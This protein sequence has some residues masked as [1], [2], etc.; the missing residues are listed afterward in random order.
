[1]C[2]VDFQVGGGRACGAGR[3]GRRAAGPKHCR[4]HDRQDGVPSKKV[5]FDL[6]NVARVGGLV[7]SVFVY[8]Q[9]K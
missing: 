5:D 3:G 9:C 7:L 4:L 8:V 2:I 6:D 1:M